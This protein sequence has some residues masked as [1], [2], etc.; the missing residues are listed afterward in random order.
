MGLAGRLLLARAGQTWEGPLGPIRHP[1]PLKCA[2]VGVVPPRRAGQEPLFCL[3]S[4]QVPF[5]GPKRQLP[6]AKQ[7]F[8]CLP[9]GTCAWAA[10]KATLRST[11]EATRGSFPPRCTTP[12]LP[13]LRGFRRRRG[14]ARG[15]RRRPTDSLVPEGSRLPAVA[16]AQ[17]PAGSS[18]RAPSHQARSRGTPR[19]TR[20]L[21]RQAPSCRRGT[22]WVL[23]PGRGGGR[24][25]R[26]AGVRVPLTPGRRR[27]SHRRSQ[28]VPAGGGCAPQA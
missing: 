6:P 8:S 15:R 21:A 12:V 28:A 1:G 25:E 27:P 20:P 7:T 4:S 9:A 13:A 2:G 14:P 16:Q 3:S 19:P 22:L 26:P 10:T 17:L 18:S 24:S 11:Q 5:K 23:A